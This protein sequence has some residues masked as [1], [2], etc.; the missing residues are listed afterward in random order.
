MLKAWIK[1][2][3]GRAGY[4][5]VNARK[6]YS[7]DG[8]STIHNDHFR[9][10]PAFRAAYQR[11]VEA[12]HGVDLHFEWRVHVALW[13]ASSALRAPGDF[14]ECGVN[15][16]VIS[17]AIMQCLNWGA[18]DRRFF[19]VDTFAGPV[20]S[21]FSSEEVQRGRLK[22][23]ETAIAKG[24]YV[25]DIDRIRANFAEWPNAVVLQGA[26][27]EILPSVDAAQVAFLHLDMNCAYPERAALEYFWERLSPGAMVL[28]DD[29]AFHG[30]ESQMEAIDA[31]SRSLGFD[32]LSL[33]TGQGLIMKR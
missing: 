28:L 7:E 6:N 9:Q 26:V 17:S 21:Q 32:V 29:Y 31:L 5:V 20:T 12:G 14:V 25:T 22:I 16:G 3:L 11:G 24:G 30:Y 27:P 10:D 18:L 13:A 15:A 19:L 4:S 2:V 1:K 23:V 8:L 33:P